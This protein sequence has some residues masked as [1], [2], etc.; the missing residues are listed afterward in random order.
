MGQLSLLLAILLKR[1]C[2]AQLC[3]LKFVHV[4]MLN[5]S[6][7]FL[8]KKNVFVFQPIFQI[9]FQ[10]VGLTMLKEESLLEMSWHDRFC[11]S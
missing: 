9:E 1:P 3:M 2:L 5:L 7:K 11:K 8:N 10:K 6:K 4:Y